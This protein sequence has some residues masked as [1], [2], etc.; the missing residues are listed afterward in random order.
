MA[1]LTVQQITTAGVTPTYVACSGGGD[2]FLN[3]GKTLIEVKNTNA[4]TRDVTVNSQATCSFGF[5]HDIVNT[6]GATTGDEIM[7][8]FPTARFN[9]ATGM[10]QL[11]YSAVTNL[12]IAVF[13]Q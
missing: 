10:V 2:Q 8:P 13:T 7:G 1:T 11:T 6:I 9:D 3:N 4:A 12:T 5:D